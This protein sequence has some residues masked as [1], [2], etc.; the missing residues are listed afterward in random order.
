[1][2]DGKT[3]RLPGKS[4]P[5]KKT[6]HRRVPQEEWIAVAVPPI[7]DRETFAAAQDQLVRNRKRSTRN[8]KHDYLL[9]NGRLRCGQ[10]GS[11]MTGVTK[12]GG[13]QYYGCHRRPFHD[14]VSR[15]TK[16]TI[17]ATAI[18]SVVWSALEHTLNKPDLIAAEV[19][20][21]RE[22]TRTQQSDLDRDRQQYTRL[23]AQCEKDLK[24]WEV[25]YLGEAIDLED[26]K[27]KKAE[28]DARRACAEQE[29]ARL[30]EQRRLLE[31]ATLE[32]A[33][34]LDYCARV[35]AKLRHFTVEEKHQVLEALHIKV[36]WHPDW[37]EP[38]ITG[39]V[40][41]EVLSIA[42]HSTL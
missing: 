27:A 6:R 31:H 42:S 34:L 18:E 12:N 4:N 5:D 30:E 25:A 26:F 37:P 22:G 9:V 39:G 1:M 19:E 36:T 13:Q 10:C 28:V 35:R 3:Q 24:R 33:A 32:T 20:K 17:R 23:L 15:H 2:Y 29:L 7:I 38:K 11:A 14:Q 21:Q 40:P 16:R 8:R 41:P